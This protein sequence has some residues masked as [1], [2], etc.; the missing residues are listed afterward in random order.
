MPLD[1]VVIDSYRVEKIIKKTFGRRFTRDFYL[2]LADEE[3]YCPPLSDIRKLVK[4][5]KIDRL[6]YSAEKFDC[7]DFA[8]S[9]KSIFIKHAYKNKERR[10]P[11]CLGIIMGGKLLG[12]IPHAINI[13]IS[14]Q[15]KVY[16]IEPQEDKIFRPRKSDREIYFI[17]I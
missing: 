2:Q 16:L 9:L 5:N 17:Y 11:H 1:R 12:N 10:Y 14:N 6:T 4:Q 15:L 8:V 13:V 7:D 3:Y